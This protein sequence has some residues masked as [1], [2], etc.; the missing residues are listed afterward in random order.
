[1]CCFKASSWFIWNEYYV[2]CLRHIIFVHLYDYIIIYCLNYAFINEKILREFLENRLF[3]FWFVNNE[4]RDCMD[5]VMAVTHVTMIKYRDIV[6]Y[7]CFSSVCFT[8]LLIYFFITLILKL[9]FF[10]YRTRIITL[11]ALRYWR[12]NPF[13]TTKT[14][15]C[16]WTCWQ[17]NCLCINEE[18]FLQ[19]FPTILKRML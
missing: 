10:L 1:M 15:M 9:L 14:P 18:T 13:A 3:L 12:H 8:L 6:I 17:H 11:H 16:G 7:R 5:D 2:V 19:D 4:Y